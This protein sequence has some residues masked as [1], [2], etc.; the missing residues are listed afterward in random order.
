METDQLIRLALENGAD[1]AAF[2]PVSKIPFDPEFRK[3]CESN[4]C[5]NYGQCWTCPPFVGTIEELIAKAKTYRVALVYQTISKIEDSFDIEG[6][7]EA[8]NRHNRIAEQI[9]AA[10]I[11]VAGED[12]L[13]LSAGGCRICEVCSKR[14]NQPCRFPDRALSSL[15]TYGVSVSGLAQLCGLNYINGKNTVTYF[16]AF[17]IH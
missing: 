6:M 10:V 8:G 17:F 3:I 9:A 1:H 13:H 5:G 2:A 7:L 14:E 12:V 15:E 16:G 4:T 11:P